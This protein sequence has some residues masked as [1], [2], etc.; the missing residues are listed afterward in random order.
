MACTLSWRRIAPGAVA[1]V[2]LATLNSSAFAHVGDHGGGFAAGLAHPFSGLDHVLA[3]VAVGL[4]ASQLGRPA[5]WLLPLT[6]PAVM[7]LGAVIGA[8]GLALPA[9]ETALAGTVLVLGL[10][11]A[12]ALRPSVVVSAT[13]IALFAMV[14]GYSHGAELP[15]TSGAL[16]YGAGF[17]VATCVLHAIGLTLG[18]L[19]RGSLARLAPR[20]I[21]AVIAGV[22]VVLLVTA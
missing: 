22:G 6:F 9:I 15:P 5:A 19:P 1:V 2:L 18:A 16:A 8:G 11:I 17:I 21:G 10:V 20:A 14:H 3:M 12:L 7:A 13:V 4:W